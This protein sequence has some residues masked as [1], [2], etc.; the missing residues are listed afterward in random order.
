VSNSIGVR[1]GAGWTDGR[2]PIGEF[3]RMNEHWFTLGF[4]VDL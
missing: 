4:W 1:L 2:P 3:F